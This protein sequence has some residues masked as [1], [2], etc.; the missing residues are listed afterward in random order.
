MHV[1]EYTLFIIYFQ[2][3]GEISTLG[4]EYTKSCQLFPEIGGFY[5]YVDIFTSWAENNVTVNDISCTTGQVYIIQ[6][7]R[8]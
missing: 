8:K 1:K 7:S 6:S 2:K 5:F 3:L 4:Q